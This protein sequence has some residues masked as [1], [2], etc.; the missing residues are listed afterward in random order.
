[1]SVSIVTTRNG[2]KIETTINLKNSLTGAAKH[3][4]FEIPMFDLISPNRNFLLV[5]LAMGVTEDSGRLI[6]FSLRDLDVVFNV[7]HKWVGSFDYRFT[8]DEK[9]IIIESKDTTLVF[10]LNGEVIHE[11]DF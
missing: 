3:I 8:S 7:T 5:K 10:N 2:I 6:L 11:R 1:M 4:F 9:H